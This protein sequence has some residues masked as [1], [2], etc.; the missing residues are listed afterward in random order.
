[1]KCPYCRSAS[2]DVYNTRSTKFGTQIWRRRR[3]TKCG[4]SFTTYEQPDLAFLRVSHASGKP[5]RYSR[6]LLFS[7]IYAAFEGSK[8][9]PALIDAVTDTVE[10]KI[11]DLQ[12]DIVTSRQIAEI[13]LA[14]LQH[15]SMPAFLRYLS[16]HAELSTSAELRKELKKYR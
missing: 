5:A 15:F 4:Q 14:T 10:A 8:A 12:L 13:V 1:L 7:E 11:L 16:S 6:A 9:Q 2:S 3:C